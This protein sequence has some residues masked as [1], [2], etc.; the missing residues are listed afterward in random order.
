[1]M[2]DPD[3]WLERPRARVAAVTLAP[4][5]EE[6]G[7]VAS[8]GDGVAMLSG[9]PSARLDELLHFSTGQL[10]FVHT[11][12]TEAIGAVL[13]DPAEGVEAG[14]VVRGTGD[15][16]RTPVGPGLLGRVVDPMGRALDDGP[17]I[18]AETYAPIERPAPG[19]RRARPG[20]RAGA[21]RHPG[22]RFA[23]R[24]RPWPA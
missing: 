18:A 20:D 16:V 12:E 6:I 22:D 19:D 21:D 8:V 5:V 4:E 9:L 7:R 15:V 17:P 2:L 23:V 1:M 11:L 10:G 24:A 3:A 14:T 13:L